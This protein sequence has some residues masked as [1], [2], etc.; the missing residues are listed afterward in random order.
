ML[1]HIDVGQYILHLFADHHPNLILDA[2]YREGARTC[3]A[4]GYTTA[5]HFLTRNCVGEYPRAENL[6]ANPSSSAATRPSAR[7]PPRRV[8]S[9]CSRTISRLI[10]LCS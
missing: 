9:Y 6:S 2:S 4:Y 3:R 8:T 10:S 1:C 7:M 5:L